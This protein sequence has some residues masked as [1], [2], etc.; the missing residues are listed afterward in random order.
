LGIKGKE[1]EATGPEFIESHES[2]F[3]P[4]GSVSHGNRNLKLDSGLSGIQI[5]FERE[6]LIVSDLS[7]RRSSADLGVVRSAGWSPSSGNDSGNQR[8]KDPGNTKD[9]RIGK[10]IQ[11]KRI[12]IIKGFRS[13]QV[14]QE[15]S[16]P[17]FLN[18]FL[19]I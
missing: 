6:S 9:L 5:L 4:G 8:L 13:T 15:H 18:G 1:E 2:L 7:K 17:L 3:D 14:E 12:D 19:G 10:E 16:D 11:Q